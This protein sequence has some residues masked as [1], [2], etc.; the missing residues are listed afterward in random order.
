MQPFFFFF[1]IGGLGGSLSSK[2]YD[3]SEDVS[4]GSKGKRGRSISLFF[5]SHSSTLVWLRKKGRW[6]NQDNWVVVDKEKKRCVSQKKKRG[7]RSTKTVGGSGDVV[8]IMPHV[9]CGLEWVWSG[10]ITTKGEMEGWGWGSEK[11][12]GGDRSPWTYLANV[13]PIQKNGWLMDTIHSTFPV[14][15]PHIADFF[16]RSLQKG[17]R[18]FVRLRI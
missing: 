16:A 5:L 12:K 4:G 17:C 8:W 15:A 1:W 6:I 2:K 11:K 7:D 18:N 14:C 3:G 9:W 13:Y 10:W